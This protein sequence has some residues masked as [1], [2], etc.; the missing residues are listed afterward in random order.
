MQYSL[1]TISRTV[2]PLI[3]TSQKL[4]LQISNHPSKYLYLYLR[5]AIFDWVSSQA[6]RVTAM[7][8]SRKIIGNGEVREMKRIKKLNV[9]LTKEFLLT[10]H[11][12][13]ILHHLNNKFVM[14]TLRGW[15]IAI[16]VYFC[17]IIKLYEPQIVPVYHIHNKY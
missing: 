8:I 16:T 4:S 9:I 3:F 2:D 14:K 12:H 11:I 5:L 7:F 6:S 15:M 17:R 13:Y 10:M 1:R